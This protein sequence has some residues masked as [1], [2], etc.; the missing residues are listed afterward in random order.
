MSEVLDSETVEEIV[1]ASRREAEH[2]GRAVSAEERMYVLHSARC[3]A[4]GHDVRA[5]AFSAALDRGIDAAL[6]SEHMDVPVVLGI[7]DA[8]GDLEPRAHA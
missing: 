2:V 5:C 3:L 1:G 6:W 4:T 8:L 7:G